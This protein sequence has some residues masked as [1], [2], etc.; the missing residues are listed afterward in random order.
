MYLSTRIDFV[1][2]IDLFNGDLYFFVSIALILC[3]LVSRFV[4]RRAD[5]HNRKDT[6]ADACAASHEREE[7]NSREARVTIV[8]VLGKY[9][10]GSTF[11]LRPLM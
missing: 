5:T 1:F 6:S 11:P 4:G 3:I 7:T 8:E 10:D 9:L 2:I